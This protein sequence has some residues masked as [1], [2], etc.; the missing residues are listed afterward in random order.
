MYCINKARKDAS[1][2][3]RR[4]HIGVSVEMADAMIHSLI[5]HSTERYMISQLVPGA[6]HTDEIERLKQDHS[7]LDFLAPDY[8]QRHAELI[9]RIRELAHEDAEH[10][11]PDR[12]ELV[13][14]WK[15]LGEVWREL[16]TAE[17]RDLLLDRSAR[18]T[19][20]ENGYPILHL[21]GVREPN[22]RAAI[23]AFVAQSRTP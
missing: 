12:V 23:A 2:Y 19:W 20:R 3:C 8:D 1:Y 6:N 11:N 22:A 9:A 10:P 4:C 5:E 7:E 21:P 13:D 14:S 16:S 15:T 17:K 18:I